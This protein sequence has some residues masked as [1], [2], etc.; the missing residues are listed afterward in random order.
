MSGDDVKSQAPEKLPASTNNSQDG[1]SIANNNNNNGEVTVA[2]FDVESATVTS[3][4]L[5][6]PMKGGSTLPGGSEV[7][8]I[9]ERIERRR[10]ERIHVT[11]PAR[12]RFLKGCRNIAKE[13]GYDTARISVQDL[14]FGIALPPLL[15][16]TI[17]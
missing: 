11:F 6:H 3:T 17:P 13:Q 1:S 10:E 9:A 4:N 2:S 15:S 8:Q 14:S 12:V 7:E 16:R 5:F